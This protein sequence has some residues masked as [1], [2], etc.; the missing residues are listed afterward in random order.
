MSIEVRMN[1]WKERLTR[2]EEVL[3]GA[4]GHII[5]CAWYDDRG[6]W[7][8][9]NVEGQSAVLSEEFLARHAYDLGVQAARYRA[10]WLEG[11]LAVDDDYIPSAFTD[12]GVGATASMFTGREVSFQECTS[13]STDHVIKSWDDIDKLR[14]DPENRWIQW[15]LDYW[16]GFS[17]AYSEGVAVVGHFW[18]S[19]LDFANDYRGNQIFLDMYLEPGQVER[20]VAKCTD[21]IIEADRFFREQI[22]LLR[23]APSGNWDI[24]WTRPGM[25]I[26]NGDPVDMISAEMGERF[27]HSSIERLAEYS[28][29]IFFHHH[30]LGV[31]RVTSVSKIK[32]LTVQNFYHDPKC[33]KVWDI[34][35]DEW[36]AASNRAAIDISQPINEAPDID[37]ALEKVSRG[38]FIIH[39]V[40]KTVDESKR[41]VE[42]VRKYDGR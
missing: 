1:N 39:A 35:D 21:L 20:L 13:Y 29:G 28:G 27:N 5:C 14:F 17:S 7:P 22:P 34:L 12:W 36:I 26:L 42:K 3:T 6:P 30:T 15:E 9:Y 10:F 16:R 40:S 8:D 38:R 11:Q 33:A 19:P 18:R 25:L 24:A 37:A 2:Q 32:G 23:T 4:R 31:S 41:L